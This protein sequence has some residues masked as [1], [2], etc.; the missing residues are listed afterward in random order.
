MNIARKRA[1]MLLPMVLEQL[2]LHLNSLKGMNVMAASRQ[3]H[4]RWTKTGVR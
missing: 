1:Q 3:V 4:R 2:V